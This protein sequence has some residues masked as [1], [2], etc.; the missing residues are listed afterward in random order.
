MWNKLLTTAGAAATL[1][2]VAPGVA[3]QQPAPAAQTRAAAPV[4]YQRELFDYS[5]GGR[6]D[7]FRS[8]LS[9]SDV[10]VRVEDL[11]L[12]GV[13]VHPDASRSVAVLSRAGV[14]RPIRARVGERVGG[15]RILA[16]RPRSV[17]VLVEEFGVAR[18]ET[19]QIKPAP[20][21]GGSS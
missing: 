6:P 3:A 21:K 7:P 16:I 2:S 17:D 18:R 5:R 11:A 13:V 1:L 14:A 15:I 20:G 10:G 12:R 8:L 19:L 9:S 4:V